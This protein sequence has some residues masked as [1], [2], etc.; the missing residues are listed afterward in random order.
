MNQATEDMEE[1][2]SSAVIIVAC[3]TTEVA[4]AIVALKIFARARIDYHRIGWDDVFIVLSLV[5]S[6]LSDCT[7]SDI[8]VNV[9]MQ[10]AAA[11]F[12]SYSAHLGLGR[13]TAA[14]LA[15]P[16]G[17]ERAVRIAF[18]QMV[19]YRKSLASS[20]QCGSYS[21]IMSQHSTSLLSA[22]RI[23]PSQSLSITCSTQTSGGREPSLPWY[24]SKCFRFSLRHDLVFD[25]L[26]GAVSLG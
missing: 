12:A 15:E 10:M 21:Q 23:S 14:V 26:P 18:Y 19:G 1:S 13:H 24:S 9:G 11:F 5:G 8:D 7:G 3:V 2:R 17:A 16:D 6:V 22:F 4:V 25:V 20:F